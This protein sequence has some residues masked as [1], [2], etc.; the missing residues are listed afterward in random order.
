MGP[1]WRPM[2]PRP[3]LLA[4]ILPAFALAACTLAAPQGE[5][6]ANPLAT[7]EIGVTALPAPGAAAPEASAATEAQ[8][9]AAAPAETPA[10]PPARPPAGPPAGSP[11]DGDTAPA[12]G[13]PPEAVPEAPPPPPLSA[14][15][16]ACAARGGQ[17]ASAPSGGN[18]CVT[19]TRDGGKACTRATQCEGLC[20][21]RSGSCAPI[22]P[23]FGC[24]E[25]L[26]DDGSRVTL[27]LD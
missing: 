14:A 23:V 6:T 18:V 24:N 10:R 2:P 5:G 13:A 4:L 27:C 9:P 3:L 7:E 12:G 22:A 21:A 11:D 17:Y 20:L 15:A 19:R 26:Q 1:D 16:A 8:S 25:I